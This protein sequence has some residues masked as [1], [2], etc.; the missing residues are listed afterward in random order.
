MEQFHRHLMQLFFLCY[1]CLCETLVYF[2]TILIF[3]C[4]PFIIIWSV[5]LYFVAD[6]HGNPAVLLFIR[7]CISLCVCVSGHDPPGSRHGCGGRCWCQYSRRPHPVPSRPGRTPPADGPRSSSS[8]WER[9]RV[10]QLRCVFLMA[11]LIRQLWWQKC[12]LRPMMWKQDYTELR[13]TWRCIRHSSVCVMVNA[14]P[15]ARASSAGMMGPPPGMRPPMG[16]P[17]GMPPGRGA[18]MGMPPPGMRPPPPGMR[19][20]A[21]LV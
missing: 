9:L 8:R 11:V 15:C 6:L 12:L 10:P 4:I 17:M 7:H 1:F 19:G 13:I 21:G 3:K 2:I 5:L 16:P 18:P 14:H 20:K